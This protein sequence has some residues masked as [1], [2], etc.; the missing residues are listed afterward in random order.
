MNQ[1]DLI[2]VIVPVY[3]VEK[4]LP[5]CLDSII[6]ST[7][8]NLEIICIND[9][10]TDGS[11]EILQQYAGKDSRIKLINCEQNGGLSVARNKGLDAA[12]GSFISFVDSDDYISPNIFMLLYDSLMDNGSDI[13]V[14]NYFEADE[15]TG[16]IR[17]EELASSKTIL[18]EK[19]WWELYRDK[20]TVIMNCMW[21]KMYK[22]ECFAGRRFTPHIIYEDSNIQHHLLKN[23]TISVVSRGLYYYRKR[24]YSITSNKKH[25]LSSF[26]RVNS[27]IER[28]EYFAERDWTKAKSAALQDAIKFL[29]YS[30]YV[31]ALDT[32]ETKK[33][34]LEYIKRIKETVRFRDWFFMEQGLRC[35]MIIYLPQIFH[36]IRRVMKKN[37][38]D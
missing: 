32:S 35:F 27:L 4:Y 37:E 21:N 7:Y 5:Q 25:N 14:C 2:S 11:W 33:I 3:N 6:A 18:S 23:R 36:C 22:A 15:G 34:G 17:E 8:R 12:K 13:S 28:A 26:I 10:S 24:A 1:N 31:S 16:K 30:Q 9:A 38:Y 20:H 29:Y 19:E